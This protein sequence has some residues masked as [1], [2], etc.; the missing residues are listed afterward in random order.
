MNLTLLISLSVISLAVFAFWL[1]LR[2]EK[3]QGSQLFLT[4]MPKELVELVEKEAARED[5]TPEQQVVHI[6]RKHYDQH[7]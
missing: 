5:R 6:L 7:S 4:F 2:E 3:E 1:Y